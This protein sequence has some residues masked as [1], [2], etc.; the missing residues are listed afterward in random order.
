M[1]ATLGWEWYLAIGVAAGFVTWCVVYIL[2]I[3][4]YDRSGRKCHA[5]PSPPPEGKGWF[6][7]DSPAPGW[8]RVTSQG[9]DFRSDRSARWLAENRVER[10]VIPHAFDPQ[11]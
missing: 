6:R 10:K 1:T 9:N 3:W 11:L 5:M 7:T 2:V 8:M 4:L